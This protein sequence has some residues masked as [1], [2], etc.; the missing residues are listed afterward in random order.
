MCQ[1]QN[2]IARAMVSCTASMTLCKVRSTYSSSLTSF[3][4]VNICLGCIHPGGWRWCWRTLSWDPSFPSPQFARKFEMPTHCTWQ[5]RQ[6]KDHQHF[7]HCACEFDRHADPARS[8]TAGEM[9]CL[10]SRSVPDHP[11]FRPQSAICTLGTP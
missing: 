9:Q 6:E 8:G 1:S 4:C 2:V 10:P 3:G 7:A 5:R 11:Y